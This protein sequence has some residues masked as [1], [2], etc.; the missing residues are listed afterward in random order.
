M[1]VLFHLASRACAKKIRE[2]GIYPDYLPN[3]DKGITLGT[4]P[5]SL[6]NIHK[7]Q[8][9]ILVGVNVK[10]LDVIRKADGTFLWETDITVMDEETFI[11][12]DRIIPKRI[13]VIHD[14]HGAM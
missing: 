11:C 2:H 8:D 1:I 7:I 12:R 10:G 6:K 5:T 3:G 4:F 14:I 9:G 13:K